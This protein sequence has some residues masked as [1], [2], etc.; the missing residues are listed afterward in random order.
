MIVF[1]VL[2]REKGRMGQIYR[3]GVKFV[4]P[5]IHRWFSL[6]VADTAAKMLR[7]AIIRQRYIWLWT[8]LNEKYKAWKIKV[9]LL[10]GMWEATLQLANSIM[11]YWSGSRN[12]WVVG[13]NPLLYYRGTKG[14]RGPRVLDVA[15]WLEYGTRH[16]PPRPLFRPI[17]DWISRHIRRLW[18]KFLWMAGLYQPSLSW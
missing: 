4:H 18:F 2:A 6:F 8:P 14:K 16:I 9:G 15:Y 3:P 12:A 1:N 13:I 10:P 17:A 7:E 5:R 11:S